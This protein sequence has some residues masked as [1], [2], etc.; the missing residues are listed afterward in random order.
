MWPPLST[1]QL[2]IK[3]RSEQIVTMSQSPRY[4]E[5]GWEGGTHGGVEEDGV[6]APEK[7]SKQ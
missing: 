1:A 5:G 6:S 4:R 3:I 7:Q 2:I